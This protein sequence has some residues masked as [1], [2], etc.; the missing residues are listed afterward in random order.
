MAKR[1]LRFAPA[2]PGGEPAYR[3][4]YNAMVSYSAGAETASGFRVQGARVAPGGS[5]GGSK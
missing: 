4:L 5:P 2:S 3:A 1:G